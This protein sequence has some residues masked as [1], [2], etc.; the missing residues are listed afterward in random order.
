MTESPD[1]LPQV[2]D[3]NARARVTQALDRLCRAGATADAADELSQLLYGDLHRLAAALLQHERKGHT[4]Q[5]TA[6]VHEAWLRLVDASAFAGEAGATARQRFLGLAVQAMRR[7]LVDHARGRLRAKRGGG[8]A[9]EDLG[10]ALA[11]VADD[12]AELLDLDDA[13][14]ALA[15]RRRGAAQIAELRIYGGLSTAEAAEAAGMGLTTAK[16]EWAVA[17]ALLTRQLRGRPQAG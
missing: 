12:P 16:A 17:Q 3:A 4:L 2:H 10:E 9:R 13:L 7:I 5:A 1:P 11:V 8:R 14:T 6:L 15:A